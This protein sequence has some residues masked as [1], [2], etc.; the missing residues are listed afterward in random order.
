MRKQNKVVLWSVYFDSTK[1]RNEGRRVP[2]RLAIAAPKLEELQRAAQNLGLQPEIVSDAAYPSC[3]W[4]RVGMLVVPKKESKNKILKAI[5]KE[6]L[7][8]RH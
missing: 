4:L 8:I 5:G 2:K 3:P 7:S 1:T 6:I